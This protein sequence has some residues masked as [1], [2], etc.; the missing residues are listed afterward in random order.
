MPWHILAFTCAI[1]CLGV[2]ARS[3]RDSILMFIMSR[4]KDALIRNDMI[5]WL[6]MG[7]LLG[8]YRSSSILSNDDDADFCVV[9]EDGNQLKETLIEYF[10]DHGIACVVILNRNGTVIHIEHEKPYNTH[11]DLYLCH[12]DGDVIKYNGCYENDCSPHG[13][14]YDFR[15]IP[16]TQVFADGKLSTGA[17]NGCIFPVPVEMEKYCTWKYNYIGEYAKFNAS[18]DYY[19]KMNITERLC[20]LSKFLVRD[21]YF[22]YMIIPIQDRDFYKKFFESNIVLAPIVRFIYPR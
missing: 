1:R 15:D 19:E 20:Y 8:V 13:N 5:W 6:D 16:K 9:C 21:L 14:A 4:T 7:T 2:Y 10:S 22:I 11:L 17:L 3:R 12:I 18:K